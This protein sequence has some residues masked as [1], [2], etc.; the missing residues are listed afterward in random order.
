MI[1][2]EGL[3]VALATPF[4]RTGEIDLSAFRKLVRHVVAGGADVLMPLGSTGEAATIN[5]SERDPLIVACLEEAGGKPVVVGCGSNNTAACAA[6]T[7]RA[8]QLGAQGVLVVGPYYNKPTLN[9]LVAHF[10]AAGDAAPDLPV[11]LYN[12]PG[13]T[14]QNITP[15]MLNVLWENPQIVAVKE[16][17]GDIAQIAEIVRTLPP[18][19]T[20][21]SGDD[22]LA[23]PSI[24]VGAEGL[25]SVMGNAFPAEVKALVTAARSGARE[26]ALQLHHRLLPIIHALFAESNPIPIKAQLAQMG[27]CTDMMRLPLVPAQPSTVDRLKQAVVGLTRTTLI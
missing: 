26:Q 13:R 10:A 15:A 9:G 27:I 2:L 5:D 7:R 20:V 11:V 12:V 22:P 1:K 25:V 23:L 24:A 14:G 18:G 8:Q 6:M 4:T 3:S 16:S 21:L 19:K 17:S